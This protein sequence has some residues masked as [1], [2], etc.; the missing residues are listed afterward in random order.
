MGRPRLPIPR[1][2]VRGV[3]HRVP[4][5]ARWQDAAIL[6]EVVRRPLGRGRARLDWTRQRYRGGLSETVDGRTVIV[7]RDY[8]LHFYYRAV[9]EAHLGRDLRP[10]EVV[11]HLNGD[12][13]DD[14]LENL[15]VVTRAQ[16]IAIHR[17]D[18]KVAAA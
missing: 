15:Q 6:L 3:R 12:H 5:Q 18:L 17:A 8:S 4:A 10:D 7:C 13:T 1:V 16:H 14:R 2:D 9:V 11:H